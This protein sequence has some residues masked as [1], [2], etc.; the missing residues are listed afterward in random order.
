M[1]ILLAFLVAASIQTH[2]IDAFFFIAT[3]C[4]IS[5]GYAPEIQRICRAYESKGVRCT[6]VYEDPRVTDEA[7]RKHVADF[8]YSGEQVTLDRD[9]SV[10]RRLGATV[11]PEAAIVDRLGTIRYR[12]RIDNRY[13]DLGRARTTVS[14]H[15]LR[16]ALEAVVNGTPVG[17][18]TTQPVGCFIVPPE[19]RKQP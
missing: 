5:N 6:L 14:V 3:D 15:D 2:G 16:D 17:Q 9:G 10:A 18:P 19:M 13:A 12:G 8:R 7:V 4:P 1:Q 11:T